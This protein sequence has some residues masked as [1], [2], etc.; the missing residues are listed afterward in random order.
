MSPTS[1]KF[2]LIPLYNLLLCLHGYMNLKQNKSAFNF[3]L[4][5]LDNLSE[6]TRAKVIIMHQ[7]ICGSQYMVFQKVILKQSVYSIVE[8]ATY[9]YSYFFNPRPSSFLLETGL[10]SSLAWN[11]AEYTHDD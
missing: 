8:K 1:E 5:I 4:K 2:G 9:K 10:T 6:I 11:R 3:S 7:A